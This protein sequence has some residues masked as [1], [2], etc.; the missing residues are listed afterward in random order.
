MESTC[1]TFSEVCDQLDME[2]KGCGN[3]YHVLR[4][5]GVKHQRI[6]SRFEK[7]T[8]GPSAALFEYLKATKPALTVKEFIQ[9]LQRKKIDRGD[10]VLTLMAF[11]CLSN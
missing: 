8:G 4:S 1:G 3:Y 6:K 11:D 7:S 2:V 9:V 10:I 5:F